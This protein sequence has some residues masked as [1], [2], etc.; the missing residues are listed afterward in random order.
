MQA[1]ATEFEALHDA[2][3][4]QRTGQFID[5]FGHRWAVDQHLFDVA[6]EEVERLAAAAFGG[7]DAGQGATEAG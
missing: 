4:G 2:F 6:H 1:G 5:P 3:W 7:P